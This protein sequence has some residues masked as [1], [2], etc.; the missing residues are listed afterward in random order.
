MPAFEVS[1]VIGS[2]N[3]QELICQTVTFPAAAEE[4]KSIQKTVIIDNC[5]VFFDKVV[6]DGRLRKDIMIKQAGT[7]FPQ[8][9]NVQGCSGITTTITGPLI[10]I[11]VDIAFTALVPVAG[12][13]PGDEC[14]VLQAFVEG[15]KE[16]AANITPTGAFHAL[17]DKSIVFICVKA[18]VS[19]PVIDQP[20]PTENDS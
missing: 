19:K 11:D 17:I 15:E 12:A 8:P 5:Q 18:N 13:R 4:V 16:E 3:V 2:G 14:V 7:G 10:D 20:V 6:I 9:G 1:Q